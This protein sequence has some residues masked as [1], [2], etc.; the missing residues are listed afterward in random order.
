[1]NKNRSRKRTR[2]YAMEIVY[3]WM[4]TKTAVDELLNRYQEK[5]AVDMPYLEDLIQGALSKKTEIEKKLVPFLV[6][7]SLDEVTDIEYAILV[8]GSYE[9]MFQYDVPYRVIINEAINLAKSY[10]AQDAYRFVNSV[11]DQVAKQE[12]G[13][14]YRD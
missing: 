13:L 12:R 3:Q 14:E 5:P 9:L 7:R 8:V 1:M 6:D 10:G 2:V 11:L 4:H